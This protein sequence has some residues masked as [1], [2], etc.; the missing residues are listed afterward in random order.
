MAST[1]D[2]DEDGLNYRKSRQN[3]KRLNKKTLDALSESQG[4][5][6]LDLE[7]GHKSQLTKRSRQAATIDTAR[8]SRRSNNVRY[9]V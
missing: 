4:E 1:K 9:S 3:R 2:V 5:Q 7:A 6:N 8:S